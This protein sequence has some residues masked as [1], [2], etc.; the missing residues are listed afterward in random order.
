MKDKKT[1]A[2]TTVASEEA[3]AALRQDF[4]TEQGFQRTLLPRLGMV[5]QDQTEEVKNPKTGKKEIKIIT[6]AGT[7]FIE[8]QTEEED[9]DGKKIWEKTEL[10]SE[11]EAT[12][13]F[14]RKQLRYY[15][16]TTETYTSSS[17][18]D[19]EDEII[20]LFCNKAEIARGTPA[21]LKAREEYQFTKNGKTKSSLEDNRILYVLYEGEIYQMNLRG[22][23]MYAWMT[24][25]RKVLVPAVL[26]AMNSEAKEKGDINWNQ[27]TFNKVRDLNQSEVDTVLENVA[28]IKGAIAAEKAFYASLGQ[29]GDQN[30][31]N[32]DALAG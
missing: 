6:E 29:T 31:K 11:I 15:D 2:V 5:S 28:E 30:K 32:L 21:E 9:N 27:M 26:T 23:S 18:Y 4:P 24:Y 16:E 1:T 10:G 17:V 20:P 13:I 22:S 14:Q 19:T 8:K 7:F 3:L 12:I 25:S